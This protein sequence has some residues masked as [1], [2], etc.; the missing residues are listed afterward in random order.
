ME[1]NSHGGMIYLATFKPINYI[2]YYQHI[3]YDTE[4][5]YLGSSS[6]LYVYITSHG[7]EKYTSMRGMF[8]VYD[9]LLKRCIMMGDGK[10][11]MVA[12]SEIIPRN[13]RYIK[14]HE[15]LNDIITN[16][17]FDKL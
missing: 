4:N 5:T 15:E 12:T 11:S 1:L 14:L 8:G 7:N 2:N 9:H 10:F 6:Y 16:I 17:I 3:F 13:R